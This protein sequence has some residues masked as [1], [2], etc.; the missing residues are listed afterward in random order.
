MKTLAILGGTG[1]EGAGL[2]MRWALHGHRVIIGSRS[3]EKAEKRAKEMNGELGAEYLTGCAN[4]QAADLADIIIL[5]VPYSAHQATLTAVREQCQGKILVDLTVPL[6]PPAISQVNLPGGGAAALEAQALLGP[7]VTVVAAFQ[8]VSAVK[9]KQLGQP[10]DCDVL[11]CADDREARMAV[12]ELVAAAGMR[13]LDAGALK[14]AVAAESLT[15]VL[16][17]INKTYGVQGAGLR[18]TGLDDEK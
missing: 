9:L 11:V 2:A 18:I 15:P 7:G 1:K 6:Q 17:H 5:S 13:G 4:S 8:N 16:L 14:N 3:A 10:V 12:I